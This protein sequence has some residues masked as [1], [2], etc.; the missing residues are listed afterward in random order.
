[1]RRPGDAAGERIQL[2]LVAIRTSA[3][4]PQHA[5]REA[6]F[7]VDDIRELDRAFETDAAVDA[8]DALRA[9]APELGGERFLEAARAGREIALH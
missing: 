1:M 4:P 2:A 8:S 3:D 5:A 6:R 7:E 9:E